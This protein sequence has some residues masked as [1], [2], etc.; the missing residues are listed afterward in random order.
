MS[1][2]GARATLVMVMSLSAPAVAQDEL[3]I[4][5]SPLAGAPSA[6]TDVLVRSLRGL[7]NVEVLDLRRVKSALGEAAYARALACAERACTDVERA[8]AGW[9]ALVT[10]ELAESGR[11]LRL[12]LIE[13]GSEGP[14]ERVRVSRSLGEE[15]LNAALRGAV[16]ELLP[17]RAAQSASAVV[18]DGLPVGASI[19]FDEE[20]PVLVQ[21]SRLRRRM[22]PGAHVVEARARGRSPWRREFEVQLGSEL[23]LAAAL[24]K[25][26]SWGPW[27][28]GAA[29][30][31]AAG[32]GAGL[33]AS[34]QSRAD[35]WQAAC[36]GVENCAPGFTR[37][38]F[39]DDQSALS[40][41]NAGAASLLAAGGAAV[42]GA[43][44]WFVLDPGQDGPE[45]SFE[46]AGAGL[47]V[48][49]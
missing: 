27:V 10:S 5:V 7:K 6:A 40:L 35:E 42:I 14:Q 37:A 8:A 34:A 29:G 44:I 12:R 41:E 15:G 33:A 16:V 21:G 13:P 2:L 4:A 48:R 24:P 47:G 3:R 30:L 26:R 43:A 31:V 17:A 1:R 45:G 20:T 11:L 18:I 39:L 23:R 36:A 38:R 25:R 49:F 46:G 22:R 9:N 19:R 28:V 32:V